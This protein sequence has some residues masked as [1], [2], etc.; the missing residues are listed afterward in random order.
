MQAKCNA[1]AP[2]VFSVPQMFGQSSFCRQRISAAEDVVLKVEP[3]LIVMSMPGSPKT[4]FTREGSPDRMTVCRGAQPRGWRR[5]MREGE[6][7]RSL[8]KFKFMCQI[9]GRKWRHTYERGWS[10]DSRKIYTNRDFLLRPMDSEFSQFA[11]WIA[12]R[13]ETEV[14][15]ASCAAIARILIWIV[16]AMMTRMGK[17]RR[18]TFSHAT[19]TIL[20]AKSV[21]RTPTLHEHIR[22][23]GDYRHKETALFPHGWLYP[24]SN[25]ADLFDFDFISSSAQVQRVS[26]LLVVL[27][28]SPMA[29]VNTP[30]VPSVRSRPWAQRS[31][32]TKR[33]NVRSLDFQV[34]LILNFRMT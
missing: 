14:G 20:T 30:T 16:T 4:N 22:V 12:W 21:T 33:Q 13:A 15:L 28:L 1:V 5:L 10:H 27:Q 23:I 24:N 29:D 25:K 34:T 11:W 18:L 9:A 31:S 3:S 7:S 19:V 32:A 8:Q 2:D 17:T 6:I 26:S